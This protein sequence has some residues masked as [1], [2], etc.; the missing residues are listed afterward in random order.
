MLNVHEL[1]DEREYWGLTYFKARRLHNFIVTGSCGMGH[2]EVRGYGFE[3]VYN[4]FKSYGAGVGV[5]CE[6][7]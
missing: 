3:E 5:P 6:D 1:L 4:D 2:G 7:L